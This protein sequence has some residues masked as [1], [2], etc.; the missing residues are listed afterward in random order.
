MIRDNFQRIRRRVGRV[1]GNG[2]II[3]MY[4]QVGSPGDDPWNLAVWPDRFAEQMEFLARHRKVMSVTELAHRHKTGTLPPNAAAVTF[5]D[6]YASNFHIAK[7]ILERFGV[8][9]T[10]FVVSSFLDDPREPWSDEL[11]SALVQSP[12]LPDQLRL[13]LVGQI[14]Q[15]PVKNQ[16]RSTRLALN[17]QIHDVLLRVGPEDRRLAVDQIRDQIAD[18]PPL[19]DVR[20]IMTKSELVC[21]AKGGLIEIG[22]HTA[23]HPFLPWR[24]EKE[25]RT[26]IDLCKRTLEDVLGKPVVGFCYP[27]GEHNETTLSL[28]GEFGFAYACTAAQ[29]YVHR[30]DH[31]FRLPRFD[32]GNWDGEDFGRRFAPSSRVWR[33]LPRWHRPQEAAARS[34]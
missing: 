17:R 26:E 6:G 25:Q 11:A 8:P 13:A 23:T 16:T 18:P 10:V 22:G 3:L 27:Y 7:P 14:H 1:V 12:E 21:L 9:A 15:W 24:S 4:H 30:R 28:I 34:G 31:P 5:D 32:G 2:P 29:G 19:S 33:M 20:R